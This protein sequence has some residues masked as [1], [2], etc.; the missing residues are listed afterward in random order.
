MV[1]HQDGG[2]IWVVAAA[3]KWEILGGYGG[4]KWVTRGPNTPPGVVPPVVVR[5]TED[6]VGEE[7]VGEVL[8]TRPA[9]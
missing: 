8:E 9:S 5:D 3:L 4:L 7:V 1:L 2:V 6:I